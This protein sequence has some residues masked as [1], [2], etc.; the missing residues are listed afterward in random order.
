MAAH[1]GY[2]LFKEAVEQA[3]LSNTEI[4]IINH[5]QQTGTVTYDDWNGTPVTFLPKFKQAEI[6]QL[7]SMIDVLVAPSMWPESFGLVTREAAASR[8]FGL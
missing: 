7:Y 5:A 8:A 3:K 6:S 1:K 4:I 2:F